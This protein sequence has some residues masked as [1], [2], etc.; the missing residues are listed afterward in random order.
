M[1]EALGWNIALL[2]NLGRSFLEKPQL[3]I[4]DSVKADE[5]YPVKI[6]TDLLETVKRRAGK[7][8]LVACG[9]GIFYALKDRLEREG[10][11][12]PQAMLESILREYLGCHRG[13]SVGNWWIRSIEKGRAMVEDATMHDCA[14]GEGILYGAVR[15]SG[16]RDVKVVHAQC[17]ERGDDVCINEVTWKEIAPT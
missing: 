2:G 8:Q 4:L 7:E 10:V 12:T 17:K 11:M 13:E 1:N 6:L 3:E 5:W 14:L 15:A 16:G 9:R